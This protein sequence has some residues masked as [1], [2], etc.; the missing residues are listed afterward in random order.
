MRGLRLL[1]CSND[2][3][4]R[5][6][7]AH[8][9]LFFEKL[10]AHFKIKAPVYL[11]KDM[12]IDHL[13]MNILKDHTGVYLTMQSYI[14]VMTKKLGIDITKGKSCKLPMSDD[15]TDMEPHQG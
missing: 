2:L 14:E 10:D 13:S 3:F 1:T 9:R 7:R 15:I 11:D 5:G 4:I 6:P 8:V 12:I